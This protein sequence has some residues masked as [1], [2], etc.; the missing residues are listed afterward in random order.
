MHWFPL[1]AP[2]LC[3][4]GDSGGGHWLSPTTLGAG[5]TARSPL[6]VLLQAAGALWLLAWG[7]WVG[8]FALE[9]L[10]EVSRYEGRSPCLSPPAQPLSV[11]GG[12]TR[13]RSRAPPWSVPP[14]PWGGARWSGAPG[15]SP[16]LLAQCPGTGSPEWTWPPP[17]I[18]W[19]VQ[20]RRGGRSPRTAPS[21]SGLGCPPTC[22]PLLAAPSPSAAALC[23]LSCPLL[24][25]LETTCCNKS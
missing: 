14:T 18:C 7:T 8:A 6:S 20:R 24:L 17:I 21:P 23:S 11:W 15:P 2:R 4:P 25:Y 13:H 12:G 1:R 3:C 10:A 16:L 19:K 22:P 5:P 9:T